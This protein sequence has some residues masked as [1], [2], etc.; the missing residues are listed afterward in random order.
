MT[1]LIK[2]RY[3][4][5]NSGNGMLT[6]ALKSRMLTSGYLWGRVTAAIACIMIALPLYAGTFKSNTR[7]VEDLEYGAILFDY[8]QRDYFSALIEQAYAQSINNAKA[9]SPSGQLLKG[10]MMLSYGLADESQKVFNALLKPNAPEQVQ[11]RA[12]FYLAK[13]HYS[14]SDTDSAL[15]VISNIKGTVPHDL[16]IDYHYLATLVK[17]NAALFAGNVAQV[18]KSEKDSPYFPYLL[19]NLG[20]AYLAAGDLA[21]AV[22]S[23]ERVTQ[24]STQSEE[25]AVLGDRA[26]H[27]LAELAMQSERLPEAWAY[28]NNI[29]T[30]GLYSNRALLSYVWAAINRKQFYDAI[31]ALEILSNRSIALPEVQEAKVLLAHV[32][33]QGGELKKALQRNI[34]AE[35][36]FS[37]GLHLIT[38]AR[39][40]IDNQDVPREFISNLEA[41]M[42]DTDW[43]AVRPSVDY[44]KLTPFLVDLMATNA[45]TEVLKELADLYAIED[46]LKYWSDQANQHTLIL[47]TAA[48]KKLSDDAK[49][50]LANS[51]KL[52]EAFVER[53]EEIKLYALVLD[54]EERKRLNALM[55]T[56][57]SELALLDSKVKRL[58]QLDKPYVQPKHYKKMVADNH[59]R[60]REKLARIEKQILALERVMRELIGME[61]AKHEERMNYYSAQSRL[62]KARLYDM[63][64]LSLEGK[65]PVEGASANGDKK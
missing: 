45:F 21:A 55:E 54:E 65:S 40:I 22:A 56:T 27:G 4:R 11:N 31:P 46:N 36:E 23:L 6:T 10:G 53:S 30:T 61:L 58:E 9:L 50:V 14:K 33:E 20:I 24:Y 49:Q 39:R 26:R 18:E 57:A 29:R 59:A 63:T 60:I 17:P 43:Y 64:L 7:S 38:E 32:Y 19:F 16:V 62:A 13:L 25:L 41:I 48:S 1:A 37:E 52:K 2:N 3:L 42:D 12:W 51:R 34:A 35:E 5:L 15:A 28:L 47:E 44:K 8:Y